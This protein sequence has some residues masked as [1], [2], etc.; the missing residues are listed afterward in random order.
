MSGYLDD[1]LEREE[2]LSRGILSSIESKQAEIKQLRDIVTRHEDDLAD[3]KSPTER[4]RQLLR[5][6]S[7]ALHSLGG[8]L[9]QL[10]YNLDKKDYDIQLLVVEAEVV[11]P[12]NLIQYTRSSSE[13][14]FSPR[15]PLS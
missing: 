4:L 10:Y 2:S 15:S 9:V 5:V 3:L 11:V 1:E 6:E 8:E 13:G 12:A 7:R 14:Q